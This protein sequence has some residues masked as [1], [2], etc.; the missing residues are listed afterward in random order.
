MCSYNTSIKIIAILIW[1]ITSIF[2]ILCYKNDDKQLDNKQSDKLSIW[3]IFG[4]SS[5]LIYF[6]YY[7]YIKIVKMLPVRWFIPQ[8]EQKEQK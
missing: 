6:G 8:Q 2:I 4:L 1:I 3:I 5:L 7:I